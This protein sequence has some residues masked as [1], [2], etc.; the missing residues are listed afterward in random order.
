MLSSDMLSPML[1][2]ISKIYQSSP[3]ISRRKQPLSTIIF[4]SASEKAPP[5][6]KGVVMGILFSAGYLGG[7]LGGI[8]SGYLAVT[9]FKLGFHQLALPGILIALIS[10]T[11]Y[12]R[13]K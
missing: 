12:M 5:S 4:A 10:L 11:L 1:M 9:S 2:N 3:C 8:V 7:G 6:Y 13:A